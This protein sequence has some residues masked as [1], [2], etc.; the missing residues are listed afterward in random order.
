MTKASWQRPTL[1][2][3][4]AAKDRLVFQQVSSIW[5]LPH[6]H[7]FRIWFSNLSWIIFSC[8]Q[9]FEVE[10]DHYIGRPVSG[11]PGASSGP[12]PVVRM[13]GVTKWVGDE[14]KQGPL[15]Y[16][17]NLLLHL[18]SRTGSNWHFP[19]QLNPYSAMAILSAPTST[20]SIRISMCQRLKDSRKT[21]L[22]SSDELSTL[23]VH[24]H[25]LSWKKRKVL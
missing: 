16:N 1:P 10:L 3:L 21:G 18:A 15:L 6:Q 22:A 11:M 19:F 13:Y 23:W 2:T 7:L 4:D 25:K 14:Q 12:V 5:H 9:N 8:Y 17:T 20:A 24:I